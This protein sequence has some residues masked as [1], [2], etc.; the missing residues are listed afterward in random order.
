MTA[1][2]PLDPTVPAVAVLEF[3]LISP[4]VTVSVP[5]TLMNPSPPPPVIFPGVR[6]RDPL[7]TVNPPFAWIVELHP[8]IPV[9]DAEDPFIVPPESVISPVLTT[10]PLPPPP[11][12][13]L[14]HRFNIP[15]ETFNVLFVF[16]VPAPPEPDP[17][18][19][20]RFNVPAEIVI[21][22]LDVNVPFP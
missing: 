8:E 14:E 6:L 2:D 10:V 3:T 5:V 11:V 17:E 4:P 1:I 18:L 13:V 15:P 20:V 12:L 7:E 9:A 19:V 22:P 21:A 16:N